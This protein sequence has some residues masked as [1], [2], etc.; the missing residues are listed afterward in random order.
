MSVR[1][2]IED[3]R[4][5]HGQILSSLTILDGF[6]DDIGNGTFPSEADLR[7]QVTSLG[8]FADG[9]HHAKEEQVLFPAL[10]AAGIGQ[11]DGFLRALEAEHAL[12]RDLRREMDLALSS[13]PDYLTFAH[14]ARGYSSLLR[15]HIRK[16]DEQLFPAA[17]AG[18]D[19]A[20]RNP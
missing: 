15:S 17:E 6:C 20:L 1:D 4:R 13:G 3:L 19:P 7:A 16:E 2:A 18:M 10:A 11:R 8:D 5:E 14:A 12:A 9:V